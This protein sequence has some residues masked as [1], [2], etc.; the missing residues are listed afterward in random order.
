MS[1]AYQLPAFVMR[2][3]GA[4]GPC[5]S[6]ETPRRKVGEDGWLVGLMLYAMKL[7]SVNLKGLVTL[8]DNVPEFVLWEFKTIR[9][10][11]QGK[12][13][14]HVNSKLALSSSKSDSYF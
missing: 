10:A 12:L 8:Q 9:N 13:S 5:S 4:Y 11:L 7:C 3:C 6:K 14:P 1:L 2:A